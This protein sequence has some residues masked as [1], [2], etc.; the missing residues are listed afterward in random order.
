MNAD[1]PH[2]AT[3]RPRC[4][5]RCAKSTRLSAAC[6][7]PGRRRPATTAT[8]PATTKED[9]G[10]LQLP[11]WTTSWLHTSDLNPMASWTAMDGE[12]G[13]GSFPE[14]SGFLEDGPS[15]RRGTSFR[16][17]VELQARN[18]LFLGLGLDVDAQFVI[19]MPAGREVGRINI[20][21]MRPDLAAAPA[22]FRR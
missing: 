10:W 1:E 4:R 11:R 19:P 16:G 2:L 14:G 9:R 21:R 17:Q 22:I 3:T 8:V 15:G 13:P 7:F 6:Q 5:G 18:R 20:I 12:S